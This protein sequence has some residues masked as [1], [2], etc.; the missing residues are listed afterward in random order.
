MPYK[1]ELGAPEYTA[2]LSF[3]SKA[4]N[5]NI[6]DNN[7]MGNRFLKFSSN[8][9]GMIEL[10]SVSKIV[11]ES[12]VDFG[13]QLNNIHFMNEYFNSGIEYEKRSRNLLSRRFSGVYKRMIISKLAGGKYYDKCYLLSQKALRNVIAD[14]ETNFED[15]SD[16]INDPN[17]YE[18][19]V[20]RISSIQPLKN[21][22]L[23]SEENIIT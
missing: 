7:R 16:C 4:A 19:M 3:L 14:L 18:D 15:Y 22:D 6:S 21:P 11:I 5:P 10:E 1:I 2:T 13:K 9:Q 17:L 20:N 8:E 23:F 12:F